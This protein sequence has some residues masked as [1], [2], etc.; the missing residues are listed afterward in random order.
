MFNFIRKWFLRNNIKNPSSP[1]AKEPIHFHAVASTDPN[2]SDDDIDPL[3]LATL[4]RCC[5][6]GNM[7]VGNL[8][9]DGSFDLKE[10][11]KDS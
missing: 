9:D 10:I 8:N 7:V 1:Q 5:E 11:T 3:T 4:Q 2:F 6:T